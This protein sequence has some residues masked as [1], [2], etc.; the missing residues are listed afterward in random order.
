MFTLELTIQ[1]STDSYLLVRSVTDGL[2]FLQQV[3]EGRI[4]GQEWYEKQ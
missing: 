1:L 2:Y 3:S 4:F